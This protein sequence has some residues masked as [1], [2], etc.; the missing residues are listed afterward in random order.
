MAFI[1]VHGNLNPDE[2]TLVA[3]DSIVS[4]MEN[5]VGTG[6]LIITT[7]GSLTVT[8]SVEDIEDQIKASTGKEN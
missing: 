4:V 7:Q 5:P 3:V 6:S 8:D 2:D 1:T